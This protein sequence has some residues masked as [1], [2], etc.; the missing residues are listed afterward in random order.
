MDDALKSIS[1]LDE[2]D[3]LSRAKKMRE[4]AWYA[5]QQWL[6]DAQRAEA[7]KA[8]HQ[9][10]DREEEVL[11]LQGREPMTWN[12][13][14][15]TIELLIGILTQNPVMVKINPVEKTDGFLAEVMEKLIT[16][17]E[18]NQTESDTLDTEAFE[19]AV[20]KGKGFRTVDVQPKPENPTEILFVE[21]VAPAWQV[22]I[23]PGSRK[24]DLSDA[25]YVITEKWVTLEDFQ[26]RYPQH[27]D[28][29]NDIFASQTD[30][31]TEDA[32]NYDFLD[33]NLDI[34]FDDY[35]DGFIDYY[36]TRNQRVLICQIEY[37]EFYERYYWVDPMNPADVREVA[38]KQAELYPPAEILKT[39]AK[40][41]RWLHFTNDI[42]LYDADSPVYLDGF[43][44]VPMFA[45]ADK[46]SKT[47]QYYGIVKSM[48]DPQRECNRRWMQAIRLMANQGTGLMGEVDAFVSLDQ[49]QETWSDPD[50]ITLL[51]SGGLGKIQEKTALAFPEASIAMENVANNAM[52]QISG[53]NPD[54]LGISEREEPGIVIRLRQQ[55]GQTIISKLFRNYKRMKK[56]LFKIK[57]HL[58][59]K[60]MPD[61]QISKILGETETFVI[62]NGVVLNKET[63][64]AAP[65]RAI[66]D[67]KYNLKF[68]DAPGNMSK[69]MSELAVFIEMMGKGFPVDPLA[70]VDK[71]DL[72]DTAKDRWRKYIDQKQQGGQQAQQFEQQSM[73]MKMQMEMEK[74]KADMQAE[75]AKMQLEQQKLQLKQQE[76]QIK[77]Q[78]SQQENQTKAQQQYIDTQL[79]VQIEN[80][81]N[82]TK[83]EDNIIK[84]K[85][86][87]Q[88][89][90]AAQRAWVLAL[91]EDERQNLKEDLE[92]LRM[93]NEQTATNM[94]ASNSKGR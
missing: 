81:K 79:K 14:H 11:Q 38:A 31:L 54:M 39:P 41:V 44:T 18:E 52:K 91:S 78:L 57:V 33:P 24:A 66:R 3:K 8:G 94:S 27:K 62:Q 93:T 56:Q 43:S 80:M 84:S 87:A 85:R 65:I 20:V 19:D 21:E 23:D 75:Q 42:L 90:Q 63:N 70:V 1:Q 13:I 60:Y 59:S 53:I 49:A 83:R 92:L 29:L 48:I 47:T 82:Q 30:R 77:A 28:K 76:I 55:Q 7:F 40:K 32:N 74:A 5:G 16:W 86:L 15:A 4:E 9:W 72:S 58:I 12:Y 69:E 46:S 51:N 35:S 68:E 45:Y 25:R 67:M 34:A 61:W 71:L 2:P 22:K 17:V 73:Q 50:Q 64:K 89:D 88:E 6:E 10:T 37:F 26:I 36:D